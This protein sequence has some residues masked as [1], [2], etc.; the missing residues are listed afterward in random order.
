MLRLRS[1][2]SLQDVLEMLFVLQS[3]NW[4]ALSWTKSL[5]VTALMFMLWLDYDVAL[6][7][8]NFTWPWHFFSKCLSTYLCWTAD[9]VFFFPESNSMNSPME[10][11][12]KAWWKTQETRARKLIL[13]VRKQSGIWNHGPLD[14][15]KYGKNSCHQAQ[16]WVLEF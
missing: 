9:Y 7:I 12:G 15:A 3:R 6:K 2:N 8:N 1:A 4:H 5:E 11:L 16:N 13:G 10:R 14:V